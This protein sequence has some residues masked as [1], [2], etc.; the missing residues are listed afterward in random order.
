M[1][2]QTADNPGGTRRDFLSKATFITAAVAATGVLGGTLRLIKPNVR[3]EEPTKFK[4]GKVEHFPEGTSKNLT[5][6]KVIV[7]SDGDG[8]YAISSIC[9]H[10]G[11]LVTPTE[12]GFQCPCHGSKYTA[13]GNVIA[14]PAPR[15]LEWHEISQEVDGTLVV[16]TAK[17]VPTG[18]KYIFA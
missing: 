3:Y 1:S 18:T 10:L 4:I 15:P 8:L 14:G 11:C 16:D 2:S 9:T 6:K 12:W 5:D 17:A 7:F 13:E